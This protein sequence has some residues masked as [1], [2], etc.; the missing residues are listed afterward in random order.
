MYAFLYNFY[1]Q[2]QTISRH[3]SIHYFYFLAVEGFKQATMWYF[4]HTSSLLCLMLFKWYVSLLQVWRQQRWMEEWIQLWMNISSKYLW[5]TDVS[6]SQ[7]CSKV[8]WTS[9][10]RLRL[11]CIK[12]PLKMEV[13]SS[14]VI[15]MVEW[16]FLWGSSEVQQFDSR[17]LQSACQSVLE[18]DAIHQSA[19]QFPSNFAITTLP[20]IYE[21]G[22]VQT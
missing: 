17:P 5:Q 20:P 11:R 16:V 18:Q 9:V 12:K 7:K 1:N 19:N 4:V 10:H 6:I 13:T 15:E 2:F 14:K 3:P 8:H 21:R 22:I